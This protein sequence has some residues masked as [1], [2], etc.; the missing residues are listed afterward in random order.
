MESVHHAAVAVVDGDHRLIAHLGNPEV[1][2][3]MRS[4]AKPLQALPIIESGVVERYRFSPSE[5]A[6]MC[7]SHS[8]TEIHTTGVREILDKIGLSELDLQC[9]IH[10]PLDRALADEMLIRGKEPHPLQHNCSGKHAGM[11]AYQIHRNQPVGEYLSPISSVQK[12]IEETVSE[13]TG[14][15]P[16]VGLD[17]CSAPNFAVPLRSAARAY[18]TLVDPTALPLER[19]EACK[20]VVDA[21]VGHPEM[22]AG[23]G[24]FDTHLMRAGRSKLLSKAGAEGFQGIG[25]FPSTTGSESLAYG[26]A[27]KIADGAYAHR[28]VS[29]VGLSVLTQLGWSLEDDDQ[30]S[31]FRAYNLKN[32]RELEVGRVR[33]NFQ[34]TFID[35]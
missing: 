26:I 9:G 12:A 15:I 7:A 3:Y 2:T 22:V 33:A 10:P 11:L 14:A 18:A 34:L 27:I 19:R 8:G 24:R 23:E 32:H 1:V 35:K 31:M 6:L 16:R 20:V 13:M 28:A 17:G 21:M 29:I 4:T 5:I 30:L 25:I